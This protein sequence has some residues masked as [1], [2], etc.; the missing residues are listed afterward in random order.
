MLQNG[1]LEPIGEQQKHGWAAMKVQ[2]RGHED[3]QLAMVSLGCPGRGQAGSGPRVSRLW[4]CGPPQGHEGSTGNVLTAIP[5]AHS[6]SCSW[7][8]NTQ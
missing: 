1:L 4:L 7:G 8:M 6:D 3:R 2:G 5:R